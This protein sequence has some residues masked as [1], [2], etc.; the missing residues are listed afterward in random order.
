MSTTRALVLAGGLG[1][2]MRAPDPHAEL[3]AEQARAADAGLKAMMPVNGR[4]F[5]D[6]VLSALA[7]VNLRDVALVVGPEHEALRR[8]YTEE[9]PPSTL[10]LRFVVQE[11]ALGTANAVLAAETWADGAAFLTMNADNLYPPR[12]LA[13]LAELDEPGLA[14]FDAADLV[15][16][17]NIPVERLQAFAIVAANQDGYLARIVE[18]PEDREAGTLESSDLISM[19]CWRFDARI[20]TACRAVPRSLRGEFELPEAVALAVHQGVPFKVLRASGGVLDLSSRADAAEVARRLAGMP[21]R[22]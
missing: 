11:K 14:A 18:K 15:R 2:R 9:A 7:D 6:Y 1:S 22:F 4:P 12:A 3:T 19:N 10:N 20:F 16:L 13:A 17:G 5:L 8:Y 21:V